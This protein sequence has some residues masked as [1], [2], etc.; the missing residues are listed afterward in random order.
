MKIV[1]LQI[2]LFIRHVTI[3]HISKLKIEYIILHKNHMVIH[4][5]Q[6]FLSDRF[7]NKPSMSNFRLFLNSKEEKVSSK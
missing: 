1:F 6:T 3:Q 5:E 2:S 7:K 4:F